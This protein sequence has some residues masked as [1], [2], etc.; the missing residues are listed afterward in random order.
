MFF[1]N[2]LTGMPSSH[3]S[4]RVNDM[5]DVQQLIDET[6]RAG[7]QHQQLLKEDEINTLQKELEELKCA[8]DREVQLR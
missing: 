5:D 2:V 6:E 1:M 4:P 7:I 8:K 3:D